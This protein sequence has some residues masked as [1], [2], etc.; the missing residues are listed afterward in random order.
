MELSTPVQQSIT[1]LLWMLTPVLVAFLVWRLWLRKQPG[2]EQRAAK[3]SRALSRMAIGGTVTVLMIVI[4]W[5]ADLPGGQ[6]ATLPLVGIF[7]HLFGGMVGWLGSKAVRITAPQRA[8]CVMGCSQSNVLTFGG[9]TAVLLL[10]TVMDPGAE[11]ALQSGLIHRRA[12]VVSPAARAS[13]A[14]SSIALTKPAGSG[15]SS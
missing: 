14:R 15:T 7:A 1:I 9:I 13:S 10:G 2:G 3:Y 4:F 11:R 8:A 5:A 12:V 6:M